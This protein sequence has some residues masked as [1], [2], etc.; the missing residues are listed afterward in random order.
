MSQTKTIFVIRHG[1]AT[2]N[3]P[4][5]PLEPEGEEHARQLA[6]FLSQRTDMKIDRLI[7]SPYLRAKQTAAVLA[8]RFNLE[9]C[10]DK[11]LREL[12]LGE[13]SLKGE[14][15]WEEL[16]KHFED[17]ELKFPQ[18]ESNQQVLNRVMELT[19]ELL[20]SDQ[21]TIMIVTHRLTMSLLLNYYDSK[22]FGFEQSRDLTNP[23]AYT[24]T[25]ENQKGKV[26]RIWEE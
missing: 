21:Q 1:L 15:L 9:C 3:E 5:D 18:G 25:I 8:K 13:T 19:E 26:N 10:T 17:V 7:S 12:E 23:D 4:D 11:R 14:A 20:Q 24:L 2:G 22:A 16:R 6:D